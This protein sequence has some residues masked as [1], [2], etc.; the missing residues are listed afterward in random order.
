MIM[1]AVVVAAESHVGYGRV[2]TVQNL[3]TLAEL[4]VS[5][6]TP[7]FSIVTDTSVYACAPCT[8][9]SYSEVQINHSP[10]V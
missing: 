10:C 5:G 3:W 8:P 6:R 1:V 2:C 4:G 9:L 7:D